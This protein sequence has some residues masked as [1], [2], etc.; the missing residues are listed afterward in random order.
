MFEGGGGSF[1]K[2]IVTKCPCVDTARRDNSVVVRVTLSP[3]LQLCGGAVAKASPSRQRHGGS[4]LLFFLCV[5]LMS[6]GS[7]LFYFYF[8]YLRHVNVTGLYLLVFLCVTSTSRGSYLLVFLC[9]T[10]TSRGSSL[11][12]FLCV[13]STSRGSSLLPAG[14][15]TWTAETGRRLS[16]PGS[17]SSSSI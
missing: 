16:T 10:S 4:S 7:S 1:G 17:S 13:M 11:L 8:L 9:V 12:V 14:S 15:G 3:P 2:K 5:T 6:R